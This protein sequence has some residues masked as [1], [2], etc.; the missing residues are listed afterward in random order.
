MIKEFFLEKNV[1]QNLMAFLNHLTLAIELI[2]WFKLIYLNNFVNLD[3]II[4][5]IIH[6]L[7]SKCSDDIFE[8]LA[9]FVKGF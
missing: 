3:V 6:R 9:T 7:R 2:L 1:I 4:Y 5:H 8:L